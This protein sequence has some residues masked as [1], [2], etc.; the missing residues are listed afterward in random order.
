MSSQTG[1][2]KRPHAA[3]IAD[4]CLL[5][6]GAL[7]AL[8]L[9]GL[10]FV[11]LGLIRVTEN[12]PG[13]DVLSTVLAGFASMLLNA[14]IIVGPLSAWLLHGRRV[15]W[16]AVLGAVLGVVVAVIV[17]V[18]LTLLAVFVGTAVAPL[19]SWE[20]AGPVAILAVVAA[21]FVALTVTLD[22]DAA[23]DL[24]PTR[25]AHRR[26]D[27]ARI[28]ATVA[29]IAF[30]AVSVWLGFAKPASEAGEAGIF[31]FYAGAGGAVIVAVADAITTFVERREASRAV[32]GT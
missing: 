16:V 19:A 25:R 31:A 2:L 22:V 23:R 5:T 27:I 10:L 11:G 1:P 17:L 12:G 8:G 29:L 14:A 7:A 4:S 6:A 9:P 20:F 18:P 13:P 26:L 15:S 30:V 3:L 32:A 21:A 28:V 24:V